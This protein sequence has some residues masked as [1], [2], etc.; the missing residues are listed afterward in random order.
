MRS[1]RGVEKVGKIK[2]IEKVG[3]GKIEYLLDPP[4]HLYLL[5][6]IYP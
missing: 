6:L 5:N 4:D 1:I 2:K 3:K